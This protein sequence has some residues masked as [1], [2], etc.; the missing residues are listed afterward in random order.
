M[1]AGKE[2]ADVSQKAL[3]TIAHH[4]GH[5]APDRA[6]VRGIMTLQPDI[7]RLL[8]A[9]A[10]AIVLASTDDLDSALEL[11]DR[12]AEVAVRVGDIAE[13]SD[14]CAGALQAAE[15]FASGEA[16]ALIDVERHFSSCR[17]GVGARSRTAVNTECA[18]H[19]TSR[20][21]GSPTSSRDGQPMPLADNDELLRDFAVRAAEHLD[22]ADERL[23]AL[24][25]DP[26]NPEA[27]D[28]VFR[29]FHTIKGMAGFLALDAVSLHAHESE[30]LLSS[31]R[32]T[33]SALPP[34]CVRGLLS[35]VDEM[36][37]LAASAVA[38][39]MPA[40]QTSGAPEEPCS[41]PPPTRIPTRAG[42]VRIEESRLD[43]LIDAIGELVIAETMTS[44]SV[45]M[46]VDPL[47]LE[48]Q[49]EHLDKITREF[50][51]MA[52]SLRM[53][54]L[55]ATFRRMA[56]LVRDV[57]LKAGKRVDFIVTGEETELDKIVVDRISDPLV[58]ALRN[59]VDHGIETPAERSAAGKNPVGRVELR[60]Y[61]AGGAIYIEV[62]DDGRGVDAERI[63]HVARDRGLLGDSE[64]LEGR[65]LLDL[66]CTPGLSTAEQITDVSGRG[67][68]M[69]V[70]RSAVEELRGRIEL[71]SRPGEGTTL[72]VRLPVT[73]A[74]IDGMV[75]RVGAERYVLPL[76]AIERSVRPTAAEIIRV[77]A[78]GEMLA[79]EDGLVPIVRLHETFRVA[80]ALADPT[81]GVV[82]IVNDSGVRAGLLA[83][84]LLGQ[85]QTVIKQLGE[86]LPEHTGITGGAIMPDGRVGLILDAAGLVRTANSAGVEGIA[87]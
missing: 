1:G 56:R 44:A 78:R 46:G 60:A 34:D 29:A 75:L 28:A 67:V 32:S 41:A 36:R 63:A 48:T 42:T 87:R 21:V 49:V 39:R 11:I 50:Q 23:L 47:V 53:V 25:S 38:P 6:L 71:H 20:D 5:T 3:R 2:D 19:P 33:G 37:A 8:D 52:T 72:A 40:D 30:E 80:D 26:S 69:D 70:V 66:V 22:D 64:Q 31:A 59:A 83:C 17:A 62:R 18:P 24:E 4:R 82:V 45:R 51:Q 76:L 86:G 9:A 15:R 65:D 77:A 79:T 35:A 14:A 13:V 10:E 12:L 55:R 84:E 58:H 81:E 7:D 61:H 68:G 43:A 16:D 54:P 85:Q 57:A 27:I 74:I 73:L